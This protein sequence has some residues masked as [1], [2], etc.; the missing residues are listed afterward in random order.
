MVGRHRFRRMVTLREVLGRRTRPSAPTPG[1]TVGI[2]DGSTGIAHRV[3]AEA[4]TAGHRAGGHY[5]ALCGARVS[6]TRLTAPARYH[7]PVCE[8]DS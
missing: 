5:V 3:T 7:C 8:R 4:F 1:C 6:P 2:A